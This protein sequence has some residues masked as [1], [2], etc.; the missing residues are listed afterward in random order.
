MAAYLVGHITVKDEELWQQYV[1][2]VQESLSSFDSKIVF[3][4]RLAS[5]L[6]GKHKYDLVVVIKFSGQ[7][8]LNEWYV[9]ELYQS[10]IPL[11]DRA[12]DVVI[13]TYNDL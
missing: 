12:A 7:T 11:R 10:L 4:G 8:V 9:S 6:A 1:S 2:G 13:T 3:R 5:V